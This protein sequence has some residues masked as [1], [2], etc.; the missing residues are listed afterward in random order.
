MGAALYIFSLVD[1]RFFSQLDSILN[2]NFEMRV[3]FV[4]NT[5]ITNTCFVD[6]HV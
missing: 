2:A 3:S 5:L 6:V 4:D 1:P